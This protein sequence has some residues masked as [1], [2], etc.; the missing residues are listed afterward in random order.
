MN[1]A[2][3]PVRGGSPGL[4]QGNRLSS[5]QAKDEVAILASAQVKIPSRERETRGVASVLPLQGKI[6]P[7][8]WETLRC[9]VGNAEL[10]RGQLGGGT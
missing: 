5:P 4:G 3:A 10:S 1:Y 6:V 8:A 9:N 2:D 7:S